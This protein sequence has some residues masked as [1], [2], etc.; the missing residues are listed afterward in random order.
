MPSSLTFN[1][2]GAVPAT[3]MFNVFSAGAPLAFSPI[4]SVTTPVGGTW[5][6]ALPANATTPMNVTVAVDP[7]GLSIGTYT[8]T[9]AINATA[10]PNSPQDVS[11]TLN[12]I[13]PVPTTPT[14]SLTPSSVTF[15][16][17]GTT[18]QTVQAKTSDGS[19]M[20]L[21]T[22]VSTTTGGNWLSVQPI[23]GTTP[24]TFKVS[25]DVSGLTA[26]TYL[27]KV[28]LSSSG[29]SNS[30]VSLPVTLNVSPG[31]NGQVAPLCFN[32]D[33]VDDENGSD[34]KLLLGGRGSIDEQGRVR[35]GGRFRLYNTS[36]G[37]HHTLETG[38]WK[39]VSVVSF[40]PAG[41]SDTDPRGGTLVIQI[42]ATPMG[43]PTSTGTMTI[44]DT[45]ARSG[46]TVTISGGPGFAP[47]GV[48]EVELVQ[49]GHDESC[50][51]ECGREEE[52]DR[53]RD[54]ER[55]RHGDRERER[56]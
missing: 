48:Q 25:A 9:V 1:V 54:G 40:T 7:T 45:G 43:G 5:L 51:A 24:A 56:R 11:V 21:N 52:E 15:N 27:G 22:G 50:R 18:S 33:V 16:A 12:V 14:L 4:A 30:P 26:G 17:P 3:Q 19:A 31:A 37:E 44:A 23:T 29:V 10:A 28:T 36:G 13:T 35:G 32:F 8:G 2:N 53:D 20:A 41:P 42:Q 49:A 47:S 6:S 34:N 39:A 46:V 55:D 38:R